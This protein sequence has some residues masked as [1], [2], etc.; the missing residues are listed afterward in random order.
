[1]SQIRTVRRYLALIGL[2]V[3]A[4][5]ITFFVVDRIG[6]QRTPAPTATGA[7]PIVDIP[8]YAYAGVDPAAIP[9]LEAP[10]GYGQ[11]D[12][13]AMLNAD[14]PPIGVYLPAG[15]DLRFAL[16]TRTPAPT[17][18]PTTT[19]T[20][21]ATLTPSHTPFPTR[22]LPPKPATRVRKPTRIITP[23]TPTPTYNIPTFTPQALGLG[24]PTLTPPFDGSQ[25]CAPG[26]WPAPGRL[27]QYFHRYHPAIDLG[28]PL[29]TP[30]VATHSGKVIFAGWRTDGYG[31]LIIVQN[32][33]FITYYAHL[34]AFNVIEGQLVSR[35]SVIGWSGS[36][37][38]STGPHIHYEIH[39][40]NVP[41]DPLTFEDRGYPTC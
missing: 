20:P 37:G 38:N 10:P 36:T 33:P 17:A 23:P 11:G 21:A 6:T 5:S 2:V 22:E 39:I 15:D 35:Q 29:N 16:P 1:M 13:R 25:V 31:N 3:I 7:P 14:I 40:D 27:T 30:L 41:V 34:N 19:A 24:L 18:T 9:A 4:S 28:I 12:A 8:L 26:G 32:G